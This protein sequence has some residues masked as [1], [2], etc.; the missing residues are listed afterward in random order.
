MRKEYGVK[1]E[2][3]SELFET[4]YNKNFDSEKAAGE[5]WP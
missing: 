3:C 4:L 2:F 5:A 1:R